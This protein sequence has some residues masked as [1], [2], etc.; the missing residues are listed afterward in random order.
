MSFSTEFLEKEATRINGVAWL[1][2]VKTISADLQIKHGWLLAL[3]YFE[4]ARTF[5]P[6]VY[7][8]PNYVGLIQFGHMAAADLGTTVAKLKAMTAIQQLDYV[9]AFYQMWIT[10][11]TRR[12]GKPFKYENAL[13]LYTSTFYPAAVGKADSYIIGTDDNTIQGV[14]IGNPWFDLNGDK[15]VTF[16]EFKEYCRTKVFKEFESEALGV[17]ITKK[18]FFLDFSRYSGLFASLPSL[19]REE[20]DNLFNYLLKKGYIV[21]I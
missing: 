11:F 16:G 21:A 14:Y 8:N 18:G 7:S 15:K 6:S 3:M 19:V 12:D 1:E 2:K 10:R 13:E 4:S 5:S 9:K 20:V 17:G